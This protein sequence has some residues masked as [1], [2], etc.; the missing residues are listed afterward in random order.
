MSQLKVLQ[1]KSLQFKEAPTFLKQFQQLES[2]SFYRNE[3]SL[4]FMQELIE[5]LPCLRTLGCYF[6]PHEK[7]ALQV[8][9]P[10]LE[11]P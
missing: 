8:D 5:A 1:L 7:A 10:Y 6:K 4:S 3:L 11:L 2:L 9:F